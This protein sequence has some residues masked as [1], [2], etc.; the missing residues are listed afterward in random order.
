LILLVTKGHTLKPTPLVSVQILR[1][2]LCGFCALLVALEEN[3]LCAMGSR[4][5]C[6]E[7]SSQFTKRIHTDAQ[8]KRIPAARP[9]AFPHFHSD[10]YYYGL[11]TYF[12]TG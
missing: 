5:I 7:L 4:P 12:K 8:S 1:K 10:G 3:F 9:A 6:A 2:K 11:Y